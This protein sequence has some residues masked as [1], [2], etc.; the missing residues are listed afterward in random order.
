MSPLD[1]PSSP[2]PPQSAPDAPYG[3]R[4]TLY[5][6]VMVLLTMVFNNIDRTMLSIVVD[7]VKA[8]FALSDTELGFLL[9]P[10]FAVVYI[11]LVLPLGRYADTT[12]VR[13]TI[14]ST[15]LF[16]WSLFTV[17]TGFVTSYAQLALMRMGVGVGEA[18]ATAPSVSM[19]ADYLPPERRASG[20]SV[21]S[22]GAVIG[23]GI[24]MMAGGWISES[25]GWRGS[26]IAAGVPGIVL[27]ILFRLTI[28]EPA[29][30]GSE[31]RTTT[32]AGAFLP[33]LRALFGT[34]TYLYILSANAFTLFASMGRNLWEPA[35]LMR[36]YEMGQFHAGTWYFLTSPLPSMLGIFLGGF[37]ADRYG[38]RDKR[39][40]LWVPALGLLASPP[41][42]VA[43]LLWPTSDVITMPAFLAGSMFSVMPVALVWSLVGSILGGFFTAPFMSTTQGVV[44]L[45][46]RA[47]AAAISTLL[48]TLIGLAGGPLVVGALAD[49]LEPEYG[50]DALR[51]ALLFPTLIPMISGVICLAGAREVA[52]DL[53]RSRDL[54]V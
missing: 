1:P 34:R 47:F 25:F 19:L 45:R 54:D 49:G 4:Y 15:C 37:L 41:I 22:M 44:P 21:I 48:S 17:T 10:A 36:T 3:S 12:G 24:G 32:T 50:R 20:M 7:D 23:M 35:F 39:W 29:R 43:F 9:G 8:E 28:R 26:F 2:P 46:M 6:L 31:G 53:E 40:Y 14:I 30:G 52:A 27:A 5:V 42:L 38:E 11:F 18:G 16:V 33:N 13:R 51:Y